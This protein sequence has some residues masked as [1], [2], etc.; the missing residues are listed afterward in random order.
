[1]V[2]A[3]VILLLAY[4]LPQVKIK[5][6]W[7]ALWVAIL[8][9]ILNFLIGWLLRGVLNLVTFFLLTSIVRIIVAAVV[10]KL[11]DKL[12][13]NFEIKGFWPALVIAIALAAVSYFLDS[14]DEGRAEISTVRQPV[15]QELT[16]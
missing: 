10:I 3:G 1:M 9:A 13:R 12:V 11:A 16:V 6:F 5:S 4:I 14:S 2:S 8:V 7:T 15:L